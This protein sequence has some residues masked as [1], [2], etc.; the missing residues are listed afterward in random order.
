ME[1]VQLVVGHQVYHVPHRLPAKEMTPLVKQRTAPDERRRILYFN[2][3]EGQRTALLRCELAQSQLRIEPA[4]FISRTHGDPLRCHR[5]SISFLG[6]RRIPLK[7]I[8]REINLLGLYGKRSVID[9][10]LPWGRHNYGLCNGGE[11]ISANANSNHRRYRQQTLHVHLDNFFHRIKLQSPRE[12]RN[13]PRRHL[14]A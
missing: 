14:T 13:A 10:H 3:R 11:N 8:Q 6:K 7:R 1:N 9:L 2:T 12:T 4:G 5:K